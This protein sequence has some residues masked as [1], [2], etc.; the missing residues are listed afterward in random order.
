[1]PWVIT[2]KSGEVVS[3]DKK[4]DKMEGNRR[5]AENKI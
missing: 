2:V 1:M 4:D 5:N 3:Y